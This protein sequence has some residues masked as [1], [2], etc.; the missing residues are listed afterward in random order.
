MGFE[1]FACL[2]SRSRYILAPTTQFPL[3]YYDPGSSGSGISRAMGFRVLLSGIFLRHAVCRHAAELKA[4][5]ETV[6]TPRPWTLHM[7]LPEVA[8]M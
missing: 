4:R 5:E 7:V 6:F 1:E 3:F 2:R 8:I